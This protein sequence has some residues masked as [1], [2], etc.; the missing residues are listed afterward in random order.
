M[1]R[2]TYTYQIQKDKNRYRIADGNPARKSLIRNVRGYLQ[3]ASAS[4][5]MERLKLHVESNKRS[6]SFVIYELHNHDC[7]LT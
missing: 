6:K 2:R 1:S 4:V 7:D 3:H 5:D